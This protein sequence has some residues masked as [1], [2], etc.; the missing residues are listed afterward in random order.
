MPYNPVILLDT[1]LPEMKTGFYKNISIH[2]YSSYIHSYSDQKIPQM[3]NQSMK[4]QTKELEKMLSNQKERCT[5][6]HYLGNSQSIT[7]SPGSSQK[8]R[9]SI[10]LVSDFCRHS[11]SNQGRKSNPTQEHS[12]SKPSRQEALRDNCVSLLGSHSKAFPHP[13]TSQRHHHI[14]GEIFVYKQRHSLT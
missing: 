11:C 4:I 8:I 13:K 6:T 10:A 1:Y 14:F 7:L 3:S 9:C 2:V 12:P 5:E